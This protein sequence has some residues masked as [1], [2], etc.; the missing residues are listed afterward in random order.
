MRR[1]RLPAFAQ[2]ITDFGRQVA[3]DAQHGLEVVGGIALDRQIEPAREIHEHVGVRTRFADRIDDGLAELQRDRTIAAREVVVLEESRRR[4]HQ[5]R[6]HRGVGE[7]LIEDHREQIL[8]LETANDAALIGQ[9]RDRVAV[10]NEQHVDRGAFGLGED[11]ADL[12]HV[13]RA[14][15]RLLV[16]KPRPLDIPRRRIAHRVAA[17]SHTELAGDR[18]QREHRRGRTAAVAIALEPPA[19]FHERRRGLRIPLGHLPQLI[20]ASR[21]LTSAARSNVHGRAFSRSSRGA[22]ACARRE[23]P[24]RARPSSKR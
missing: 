8:A 20:A 24:G 11:A 18:G 21:P 19:A 15:R 16:D 14:R 5:V 13:D 9:D 10:V 1:V 23:M 2:V 3:Q 12:V 7:H 17:A 22:I 4:Q 6:I